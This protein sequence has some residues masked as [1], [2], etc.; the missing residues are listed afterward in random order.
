ML[1]PKFGFAIDNLLSV[2]I[3]T[4][5][6]MLRTASATQN[7]DLFWAVRGAGHNF[8]VVTSFE[9]R[10]HPVGP[11]LGGLVIHPLSAAADVLRFYREFTASQPD[12]LQ[13]W[14]GILTGQDGNPVIAMIPCYAGPLDEGERLLG[15]MR[16]FGNPLADTVAPIPYV[17]M[18]TLFDAALPA[19]RLD[20][21]KTGLTNRIDDEVIAATVEYAKQIPSRHTVII[22]TEFHGAYSRVGKTDTAYY[23]RD[24]QYDLIALSVWTD[25][26]DTERNIRWTRDLF[27]AWEPHLASAVYVNDLGEEGEERTRSAYGGNYARLAA[28]K[29]KYDPTDF[30]RVN[31]NIEPRA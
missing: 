8:G 4:A 13:A 30:F 2:D 1:L 12:E 9:Y 18:Q 11:V 7:E 24:L 3:V 26:A 23:H 5:D 14:A 6:G 10:L 15:P 20:Y 19:G 16:R 25:P 21:W 28:L 22:F 29:A 17:V 27:A 31:Q